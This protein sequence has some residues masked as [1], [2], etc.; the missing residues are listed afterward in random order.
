MKI[1]GF[2]LCVMYPLMIDRTVEYSS[3]DLLDEIIS[4][5]RGTRTTK[6][7]ANKIR[8]I[9]L[10]LL[11]RRF[12][13]RVPRV[14]TITVFHPTG[15]VSCTRLFGQSILKLVCILASP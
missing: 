8:V 15:P 11:A 6:R 10:I 12:V 13:V 1:S 9:T 3:Q 4:V 7:R 5:T 2:K 14:T